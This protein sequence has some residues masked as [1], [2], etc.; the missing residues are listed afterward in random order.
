MLILTPL[1]CTLLADIS[2]KRWNER[3]QLPYFFAVL[4]VAN[5]VGLLVISNPINIV[6]ARAF[7]ISFASYAKWMVLPAIASI[8]TTYLALLYYFRNDL[9]RRYEVST[10][11]FQDFAG[12]GASLE[13]LL[14]IASD[15]VEASPE[16]SFA[17]NLLHVIT[18]RQP[19]PLEEKA[20]DVAP[21]APPADI[22]LLSE[23]RDLLRQRA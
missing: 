8:V 11:P 3:S 20:L 23:I 1:V 22:V 17:A 14:T 2:T 12:F 4:Y 16:L 13:L 5:L 10:Q 21:A 7:G 9:P 15:L 19:T 18:G 6:V